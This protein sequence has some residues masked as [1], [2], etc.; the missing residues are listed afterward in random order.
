[1]VMRVMMNVHTHVIADGGM[2]VHTYLV[3]IPEWL[4][5]LEAIG[6]P[7]ISAGMLCAVRYSAV[8]LVAYS[9]QVK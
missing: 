8:A 5:S 6:Q 9:C 1:M 2:I 4:V 7:T 3:A